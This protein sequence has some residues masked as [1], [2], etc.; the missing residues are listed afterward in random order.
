MGLQV[1]LHQKDVLVHRHGRLRHH[2]Y[3]LGGWVFRLTPASSHLS[4][5]V[6]ASKV[7]FQ[8]VL[9]HLDVE[10]LLGVGACW[11]AGQEARLAEDSRLGVVRFDEW[12][13]QERHAL[14]VAVP[15]VLVWEQVVPVPLD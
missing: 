1:W 10:R 4:E 5:V 3:R 15:R 6:L 7:H 2:Y 13:R 11:R 14:A 9:G 12:G 8:V